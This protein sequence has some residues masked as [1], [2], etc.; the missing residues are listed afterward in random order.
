MSGPHAD[1]SE[2]VPPALGSP[3]PCTQPR[4]RLSERL[5]VFVEWLNECRRSRARSLVGLS[6]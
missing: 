2:Q 5:R 4:A 3:H 1:Q 6:G